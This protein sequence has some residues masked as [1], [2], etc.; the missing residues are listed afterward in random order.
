MRYDT[1]NLNVLSIFSHKSSTKILVTILYF[2]QKLKFMAVRKSNNDDSQAGGWFGRKRS[3]RRE[4]LR[5]SAPIN[6]SELQKRPQSDA[7]TGVGSKNG[8]IP[9]TSLSELNKKQVRVPATSKTNPKNKPQGNLAPKRPQSTNSANPPIPVMSSA[10]EAMP[11]WLLRLHA[12]QRHTSVMT[13]LL[14][15]SML[16]AYGWSVYSQQIWSQN[17]RKFLSLQRQERQLNITNNVLKNN[18]A[19]DGEKPGAGLVSPSPAGT[20]FLPASENSNTQPTSL[21]TSLPMPD[22]S[23]NAPAPGY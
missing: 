2:Q 20:I 5:K 16:V 8:N 23:N 21:P 10:T 19:T 7:L 17:Y 1:K 4:N 14:V 15:V 13:F 18:M 6:K 9:N 11:V 22:Q 3:R 12:L